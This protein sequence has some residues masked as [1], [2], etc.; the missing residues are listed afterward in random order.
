MNNQE[1]RDIA[2]CAHYGG[3]IDLDSF[4]FDSMVRLA[5]IDVIE[6]FYHMP[7]DEIKKELLNV[8]KRHQTRK[9]LNRKRKVWDSD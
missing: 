5:T 6:E 2:L 7:P 1:K 4:T 9:K 3:L 8:L